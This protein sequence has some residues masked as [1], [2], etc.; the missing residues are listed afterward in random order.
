MKITLTGSLGN[1]SKPLAK[2]LLD[3]GH[4]VTIISSNPDKT[5]DIEA[6]GAIPAI[7]LVTDTDF[8][9]KT[10]T[11]ADVVYTMVP[12]NFGASN[13]RQYV[14]GIGKNYAEAIQRSGVSR[15]V[16]LSSI[17]AHLDEG[18][19][20]IKGSH[21]VETAL[22]KLENVAIKHL[23]AP[24]FYINFYGNT[25]MIRYKGILGSNYDNNTRLVMV[26]PE[27]IAAVAAEEI[28]QSITGKSIRYLVSDDRTTGEIATIL[29]T[30][31][32]K[33][34]L[35]W[36]EFNDEQAFNG[37]LQGGLPEEI[38]RNFVEMG[39]A[40]RSGVL[41]QDYDLNKP[42]IT[43]KRKLEVF[44]KEFAVRFANG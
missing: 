21:D 36:V 28:Q 12:P 3:A 30:A 31:I 13:F 32:G 35:P 34:E 27:D 43:S 40:V 41:W 18:T 39:T 2:Q 38:A 5:A 42:T 24:F 10:F 7:G 20:P 4:Q 22:N 37:M 33:P 14:G 19:G 29:G 16:N 1:I 9:T 11:G 15:I 6:L 26:H 44:A 8:L 17:G 23:R 25:D